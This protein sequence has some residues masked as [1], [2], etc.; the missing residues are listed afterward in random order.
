[1]SNSAEFERI[2]ALLTVVGCIAAFAWFLLGN[3]LWGFLLVTCYLGFITGFALRNLG[4]TGFTHAVV[5]HHV[6]CSSVIV[7]TLLSCANYS[8]ISFSSFNWLD[9][10]L[11]H[12]A[13]A[14]HCLLLVK[15]KQVSEREQ[16]KGSGE[17]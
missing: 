11:S 7:F 16:S 13:L 17:I 9:L 3:P 4:A 8:F 15:I 2:S 10:V 14:A 1:M 5:L 12:F 6:A